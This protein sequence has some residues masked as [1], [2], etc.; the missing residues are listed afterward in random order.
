M[1]VILAR[2][3]WDAWLIPGPVNIGQ[4]HALMAPPD[5]QNLQ[6]YGVSTAVNRVANEGPELLVPLATLL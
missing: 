2:D 1:P 3:S 5:P 4:L 6:A